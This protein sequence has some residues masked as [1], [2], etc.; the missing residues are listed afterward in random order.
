MLRN[1]QGS[2]KSRAAGH[3]PKL[4]RRERHR[5][6]TRARILQAALR[7]F[8]RQGFA[9]TRVEEITE[10]ADVG[11]GTFF[12][13]FPTKEHVLAGFAG[14]QIGKIE[15]ALET[16]R[17]GAEPLRELVFRLL[18]SLEN[19]PGLNPELTRSLL[20]ALLSS[21]AVRELAK[22]HLERGRRL[23]AEIFALGQQRKEIQADASP[24]K[25]ARFFQL[26]AFGT[27][28]LWS[29]HPAPKLAEWQRS[30]FELIWSALEPLARDSQQVRKGGA[31]APP[32]PLFRK[33][34]KPK[35]R[36]KEVRP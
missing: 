5:A 29:L 2:I 28:F 17:H 30:A 1:E 32:S 14:R 31:L 13:Y 15:R 21:P 19:E 23:L 33:T 8:A 12:N 35:S 7:L 18:V 11:K 27:M 9:A 6:E 20:V 36:P 34:A 25:L 16:A 24:L 10:A 22:P 4:S 3:K 26:S